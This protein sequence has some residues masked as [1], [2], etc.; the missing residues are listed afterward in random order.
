MH[1]DPN[2]FENPLEFIPERF[3]IDRSVG[4]HP[5]GYIPFS[6]GPRNCIGQRFA[7]LEMK[8]ILSLLLRHFTF[9]IS[10]LMKTPIPSFQLIMKPVTSTMPLI[11]TPRRFPWNCLRRCA[12]YVYRFSG[13]DMKLTLERQWLAENVTLW[14]FLFAVL[15]SVVCRPFSRLLP[16]GRDSSADIS[17][18]SSKI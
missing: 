18:P 9:S 5:Y 12:V 4:R 3:S 14:N 7:M 2:L 8:V 1:R 11:I 17:F 16:F 6:A 15:S 13:G 10:P